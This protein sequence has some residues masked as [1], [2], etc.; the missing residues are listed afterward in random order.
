MCYNKVS[1]KGLHKYQR[2]VGGN[3]IEL[4]G[5]QFWWT[6]PALS[7]FHRKDQYLLSP[8]NCWYLVLHQT[9]RESRDHATLNDIFMNNVIVRLSQISEDVI[10]L[11]KKVGTWATCISA[12]GWPWHDCASQDEMW[13]GD[14]GSR[15]R[16]VEGAGGWVLDLAPQ[17]QSLSP[18][19]GWGSQ[20]FQQLLLPQK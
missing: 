5:W 3:N 4:C 7:C 9:R 14:M 17:T 13:C 1:L 12:P 20:P 19:C 18:G 6:K 10:R 15:G 16:W 8:V 11:F 2:A